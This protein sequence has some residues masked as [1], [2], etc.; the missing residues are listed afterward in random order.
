MRS[1]VASARM[2]ELG[3]ATRNCARP[4]SMPTSVIIPVA[5]VVRI[6]ALE[7]LV[8]V[9]FCIPMMKHRHASENSRPTSLLKIP[10]QEKQTM[11][12]PWTARGHAYCCRLALPRAQMIS[13]VLKLAP[14]MKADM[15]SA[16]TNATQRSGITMLSASCES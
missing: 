5:C 7:I 13:M 14:A 3:L 15:A 10:P 4:T 8:I 16:L 6:L 12:P 9:A 11:N 2:P 1:L